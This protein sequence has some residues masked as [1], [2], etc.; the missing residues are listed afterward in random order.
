MKI[1]LRRYFGFIWFTFLKSKGTQA[2]L[3]SKR[4]VVMSLFLPVFLVVQII[5]WIG[6]F[7]DDVF[8]S[9]YRKIEIKD[10]I[11]IVGIPRSGTTFL[12]RVLAKDTNRFT[13]FT[14]WELLFAPSITE[15]MIILGIRRLDEKLGSPLTTLVAWIDRI[16]FRKLSYIQKVSLSAPWE[17][18]LVLIPI[19]ACFLLVLPFPFA[20]E[21]W[22]LAYF[23]DQISARDK[24]RIMAFYRTCLQRHLYVWGAEKQLLSKNPSFSPMIR[25]LR[26]V[27][28]DCK[29]ICCMRNPL[30][31]VPSLISTMML[32]AQSFDNNI[33]GQ[34]F[35]DQ[36][37]DM[38][39]Y[40]YRHLIDTLVKS[41]KSQ[42]AFVTLETLKVD[43]LKQVYGIYLR[44]KY[45]IQPEFEY[46][47]HQE[48]AADRGY[49]S[50]HTYALEQFELSQETIIEQFGFVFKAFE[51]SHAY[52]AH[53]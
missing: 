16:V 46:V 13:T 34:F 27:F 35:R 32:G 31:A 22:Q 39:A 30:F 12:H 38:L 2:H 43:I 49:K 6:F 3:T 51:F 45:D 19:C 53:R 28:P 33:Q 41:P 25:S 36:L 26:K 10:P 11:F 8:F 7:I 40:F 50:S 20:D 21:L 52:N 17:D 15:R 18:Y 14:L 29:I 9:E 48:L 23:D 1:G 4:L 42:H 47:L 24:E 5:H 37:I 44:F